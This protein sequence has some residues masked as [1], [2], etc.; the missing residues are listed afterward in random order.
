M[1]EK[2]GKG[3]PL[4]CGASVNLFLGLLGRHKTLVKKFARLVD[5]L[6]EFRQKKRPSSQNLNRPPTFRTIRPN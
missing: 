3:R 2:V 6:I 1:F 4:G 5:I